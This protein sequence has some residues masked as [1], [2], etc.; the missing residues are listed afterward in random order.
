MAIIHTDIRFI[1]PT[2]QVYYYHDI[3]QEII[4]RQSEDAAYFILILIKGTC[5]N[6]REDKI[7]IL[8]SKDVFIANKKEEFTNYFS[9]NSEFIE[10]YFSSKL[11]Q[12]YDETYDLL[13]PFLNAKDIK[14]FHDQTDTESF[15]MA[16]KNLLKALLKR[17]SKAFVLTPFW[18]IILELN[19]IYDCNGSP[20]ILETD[21]NYA[22]IVS[23]IDSH[24]F[25]TITLKRISENVY[26][27]V[28]CICNTIKKI[29]GK[30]YYDLIRE[31][32]FMAA[33]IYVKTSN[34]PFYKI[35]QK[36]G[37]ETYSTFYRNYLKYY[38]ISPKQDRI[39]HQK[40]QS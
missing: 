40:K 2:F 1:H 29:Y 36:C 17:Q 16:L 8:R 6:Q 33:R 26:L 5:R 25:N 31:R 32:R 9:Q 13:K 12:Q 18:Q 22:K 14:V 38:G 20:K 11:L 34:E 27:S 30:T 21:S 7:K 19:N 3:D 23:Y 39:Q 28:G 4:H 37:F 10:I 24:L 15:N 35:A